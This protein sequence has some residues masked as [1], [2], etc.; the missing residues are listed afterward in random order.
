MTCGSV[1][2]DH[3]AV[4]TCQTLAALKAHSGSAMVI[5]E[6]WLLLSMHTGGLLSRNRLSFPH[7]DRREADL[8]ACFQ[9]ICATVKPATA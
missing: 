9:V 3:N 4:R 5:E 8:Y 2:S 1:N 7:L 6:T